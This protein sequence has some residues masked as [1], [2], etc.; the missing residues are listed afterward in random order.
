MLQQTSLSLP[1][2][3]K[4]RLKEAAIRF[5]FSSE[6]LLRRIVTDATQT[7]LEIPEESLDAYKHPEKIVEAYENALRDER[8]GKVLRSLPR[9]I[10]RHSR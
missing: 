9:S 2:A 4:K 3:Q 10:T 1:K 5:G 8:R 6:E 7:L